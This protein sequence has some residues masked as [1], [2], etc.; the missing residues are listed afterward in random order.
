MVRPHV[1]EAQFMTPSFVKSLPTFL[2]VDVCLMSKSGKPGFGYGA[3]RA[4]KGDW[5]TSAL[6]G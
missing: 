1:R 4:A 2:G 3:L 6:N 5:E